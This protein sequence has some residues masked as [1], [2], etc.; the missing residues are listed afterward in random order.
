MF[1][2]GID[3]SKKKLDVV[4]LRDPETLQKRHKT[5]ANTAEGF[6]Q[7]RRWCDRHT[8]GAVSELHVV[9]EATGPYHEAVALAL[10]EAGAVVSVINPKQ[11]KDFAKGLGLKATNDAVDALTIARY[12]ALVK[13]RRW[14]PEPPEYRHLTVLLRRLEALETDQ[15]RERNRLEKAQISPTSDAVL[16]SIER[17]LAFLEAERQRLLEMIEAH[18]DS[19]PQL[20]QDRQ[21]LRSI[22][23]IG[24]L[25][26]VLMLALL[27]GGSRFQSAAQFASYLGVVPSEHQSGE[28]VRKKPQL[29][30]VGPARVRAK[31]YMGAVVASRYNPDVQALYER[32]LARGYCKMA[33]LGAAMRKLAHIC[34]GVIK[35]Q[36]DYEPQIV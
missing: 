21:R 1:Y 2:I 23:G 5:V 14:Q 18:I 31:L 12:G 24:P 30:K 17:A 36:A 34:F 8:G 29:T 7:L 13:P 22:P 35:N 27:H 28:S 16:A 25:L 6:E 26:S 33:A 19:H 20:K 10:H 15:Q 3:V 9:M 32:L 11:L 4:W